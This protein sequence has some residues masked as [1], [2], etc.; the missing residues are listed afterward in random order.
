MFTKEVTILQKFRQI[1]ILL[2]SYEVNWFHEK[3]G[4]LQ[5]KFE[6]I[7]DNTKLHCLEWCICAYEK[8]T[9]NQIYF[10]LKIDF[11]KKISDI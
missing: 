4:L 11:T 5:I 9:R 2:Q 6:L 1:N 7:F 10:I 3:I 8:I